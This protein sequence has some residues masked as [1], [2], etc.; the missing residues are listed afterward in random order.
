MP[1]MQVLS[2][3]GHNYDIR[4]SRVAG[5]LNDI[6][7][8]QTDKE[9]VNNKTDVLDQDSTSAQY[10]NA[11]CVYNAIQAVDRFVQV[12]Y[13]TTT[14]A[15][16]ESLITAGK[17][18]FFIDGTGRLYVYTGSTTVMHN[19]ISTVSYVNTLTIYGANMTIS[20]GNWSAYAFQLSTAIT[21]GSTNGQLASAK[22]VYDFVTSQKLYRHNIVLSYDPGLGISEEP[23]LSFIT[24]SS[25]PMDIDA[26]REY[27]YVNHG[28]V[29][30][31]AAGTFSFD[32]IELDIVTSITASA[33]NIN[34]YG[35]KA[36]GNGTY[37]TSSY[38]YATF[39]V[40]SDDVVEVS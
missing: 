12:Y 7:D 28:G 35:F 1:D 6:A 15:D 24:K 38:P 39:V 10:P 34:L 16:L 19:F 30:V 17:I 32:G 21:S 31:P 2:L 22:A 18:P 13:G 14:K 36:A 33:T 27:L 40:S 23:E 25:T 9:D 11:E 29:K 20:T 3:N 37:V 26:V 4:D 5:A 8:L